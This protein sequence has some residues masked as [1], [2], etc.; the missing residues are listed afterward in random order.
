MTPAFTDIH[1]ELTAKDE[2]VVSAIRAQSAPFKGMMSGPEARGGYDEMI[3]AIPAA[4]D[5]THENAVIGGVSG[6]WCRPKNARPDAAILY[7]HGGAYVLGSANAYRHFAGQFAA[8]TNTSAFVPDYGLAPERPFPAAVNDAQSVYRGLVAQGISRIVIVGDS[9]GG[10][11]SLVLLSLA[12]A[13]ASAGQGQAPTAC[14]VMSPWT[15]MAL[16]GASY[17]TRADEDPFLTQAVLKTSAAHYLGTK[18]ANHPHASPLYGDLAGLPPIQ[19]HVGTSE[20]LLDDT[21]SFAAR[22]RATGGDATVHVWQGMPHVFPSSF[23]ILDAGEQ[24]M[25]LMSDFIRANVQ[26]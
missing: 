9:A 24:A 22:V 21:L 25:V 19:M 20:V 2:A 5:I 13:E 7:L 3:G 4:N 15:D 16:T 23:G 8:R 17:A 12:Q 11:L 1:H 26:P 18:A 10:G 6:I 14:V